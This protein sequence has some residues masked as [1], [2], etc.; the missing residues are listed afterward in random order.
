MALLFLIRHGL[1][2]QTGRRLSGWTPGVHLSEP[3][4]TQ[5]DA[6]VFRFAQIPLSAIYSS[7]LERC[8]ETAAPLAAAKGLAVRVRKELGEVDYGDWTG[9]PLAQLARTKLW[10]SVQQN[11]SQVT[12]PGGE[13]FLQVQGRVL[14]AVGE[15][16]RTHPRGN[17]AVLSHGDAIRLLVSH[18]AGAH[19][20]AFQRV[21]IDTA[22][23]SVVALG[24]G[25]PRVLRVN[26]TG[27]LD[28]FGG[29]RRPG[30]NVKG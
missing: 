13:S 12:F 5:A 2:D 9:R 24:S 14:H 6:L 27:S 21:V 1:T 17:V 29:R 30:G 11:P 4:R 28:A 25:P 23:V 26:D 19:L 18:L 20:D 8:R 15:I 7:P 3:G 16:A 10:K 22:S